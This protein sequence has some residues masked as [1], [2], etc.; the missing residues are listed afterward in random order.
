MIDLGIRSGGFARYLVTNSAAAAFDTTTYPLTNAEVNVLTAAQMAAATIFPIG[1]ALTGEI[2]FFGSGTAA[3][4]FDYHLWGTRKLSF[5]PPG[6]STT[7]RPETAGTLAFYLGTGTATLGALTGVTGGTALT[8]SDKIV[9]TLTWTASTMLAA[10]ETALGEGTSAAYS[11]TL[12][13]G[14][15]MLFL[16]NL[17]RFNGLIID[18]DMTG[19]T[20]GNALIGTSDI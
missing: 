13:S 2:V 4:T 1:R 20:S 5:C 18:F 16:P 8:T 14:G 17:A 15:N 9:K 19:A 11:S 10:S 12:S 7:F 6:T 3:Q